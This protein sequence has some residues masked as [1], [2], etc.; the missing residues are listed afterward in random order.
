MNEGWCISCRVYPFYHVYFGVKLLSCHRFK[1]GLCW[2]LKVLKSV[3][4]FCGCSLFDQ[5]VD[6]RDILISLWPIVVSWPPFLFFCLLCL[7]VKYITR[8]TFLLHQISILFVG[9][10]PLF[11]STFFSKVGYVLTCGYVGV[12]LIKMF[13]EFVSYSSRY[14]DILIYGEFEWVVRNIVL[15]IYNDL[16]LQ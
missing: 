14:S 9:V 15:L 6:W 13:L 2:S 10:F 11:F 8:I 7:L 3:I 5:T 12:I 4:W 16:V 1:K